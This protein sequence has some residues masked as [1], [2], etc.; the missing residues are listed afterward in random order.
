MPSR[1]A[2]N[3]GGRLPSRRSACV[4]VSLRG[5]ERCD[6]RVLRTLRQRSCHMRGAS[7]RKQG[8]PRSAFTRLAVRAALRCACH[9]PAGGSKPW[10]SAPPPAAASPPPGRAPARRCAGGTGLGGSGARG[11][12]KRSAL[13][14]PPGTPPIFPDREGLPGRKAKGGVPLPCPDRMWRAGR[15]PFDSVSPGQAPLRCDGSMAG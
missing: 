14:G 5:G 3:A 10:A 13:P 6:W 15:A 1:S 8:R 4:A 9:R 7:R 11:R 2:S 12:G